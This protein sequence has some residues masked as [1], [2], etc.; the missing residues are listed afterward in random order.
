MEVPC[1]D[2][3]SENCATCI[4]EGATECLTCLP[5]TAMISGSCEQLLTGTCNWLCGNTITGDDMDVG[6]YTENNSMVHCYGLTINDCRENT[7]A[8][9][10]FFV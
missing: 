3:C 7:D 9:D 4:G 10:G 1:N 5:G 6:S 2:V 8:R